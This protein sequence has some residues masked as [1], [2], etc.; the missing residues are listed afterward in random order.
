MR[1]IPCRRR[2]GDAVLRCPRCCCRPGL[3]WA[4][5]PP[6]ALP[7]CWDSARIGQLLANL[8]ENSLRYS[9]VPGRVELMLQRIDNRLRIA[10]RGRWLALT[11]LQFCM[12]RLLLSRP[13]QVFG[14]A[15]LLDGMPTDL[16]DVSD[17]AIDGPIKNLR[18]KTAAAGPG[19]D[20]IAS[21][22]GVGQR[23]DAP[24]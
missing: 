3:V 8:L 5:P 20:C 7:L 18:R 19:C 11:P 12:L 2:Y 9:V 16:C 1:Q 14:R 4:G 17:Q 22:C 15:P 6:T 13:V 24:R 10:W 23:F 21:V